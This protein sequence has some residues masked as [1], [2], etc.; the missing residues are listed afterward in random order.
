MVYSGKDGPGIYDH[1]FGAGGAHE[2]VSGYSNGCSERV[3]SQ[4][5]AELRLADQLEHGTP[6]GRRSRLPRQDPYHTAVAGKYNCCTALCLLQRGATSIAT[7]ADKGRSCAFCV[8][9]H[10]RHPTQTVYLRSEAVRPHYEICE[11]DGDRAKCDNNTDIPVLQRGVINTERSPLL[12]STQSARPFE[13]EAVLRLTREVSRP[14]LLEARA[15]RDQAAATL[16]DTR[17]ELSDLELDIATREAEQA[18]HFSL[19]TEDEASV[20]SGASSHLQSSGLEIAVQEGA[21]RVK[22][23]LVAPPSPRRKARQ[24][25]ED[26]RTNVSEL[27]SQL[28]AQGHFDQFAPALTEASSGTTA[29]KKKRRKLQETTVGRNIAVPIAGPKAKLTARK[30]ANS[31]TGRGYV[32]VVPASRKKGVRVRHQGPTSSSN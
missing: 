9:I 7:F 15:V 30:T 8:T 5:V 29:T 2:Q 26:D 23:S 3:S 11:C 27:Y 22:R 21:N 16:C 6:S 12:S 24:P 13:A 14:S 20:Q 32:K 17:T 25:R 18:F 19:S 28:A 1:W 31:G 10:C 4:A